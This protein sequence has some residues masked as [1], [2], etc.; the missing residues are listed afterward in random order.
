MVVTWT[1]DNANQLTVEE[2]R[3]RQVWGSY[4]TSLLACPH[5]WYQLLC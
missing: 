5:L 1:Y 2:R 4:A 3:V